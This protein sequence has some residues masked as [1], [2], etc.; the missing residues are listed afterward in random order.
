M[1]L[2]GQAATPGPSVDFNKHGRLQVSANKRFLQHADGTPFFYLGDTAW[3]MM[4]QLKREDVDVYMENRRASGFTVVQTV[5]L[6]EFDILDSPNAYKQMALLNKNPATPDVKPGPAND[7]WDHSDYIVNKAAEKGLYVG[8]L[9]T[10][11][12][13]VLKLW[14]H[15]PVVFNQ[16]NAYTYGKF[17]GERY[18]NNP[19]I[20]WILGGD[21][22]PGGNYD[23]EI[24]NKMAQGLKAGDGGSHLITYHPQG[25]MSSTSFTQTNNLFDFGSVQSGHCVGYEK[26]ISYIKDGYAKT[27]VKPIMNMEPHYE[28]HEKKSNCGVSQPA[29]PLWDGVDSRHSGY[30]DVFSGAFGHTYGHNSIWPICRSCAK[31]IMSWQDAMKREG[32]V[33]MQHLRRLLESRPFFSRIPDQGV[34]SGGSG[35]GMVVSTRSSGGSYSMVYSC[36]GKSFSVNT[37]KLTGSTLKGWWYNPRTGAVDSTF[38][39]A[40]SGGMVSYDPPGSVNRANDW[41]LVLDDASK[42]FAAPGVKLT[43][44]PTTPTPTPTPKLSIDSISPGSG[45]TTGGT[46][47]SITGIG[48]DPNR[49]TV[50]VDGIAATDIK[51]GGVPMEIPVPGTI[52]PGIIQARTPAHA[53]GTVSVTVTNPDGQKVTK[54]NAYT[55]TAVTIPTASGDINGDNKV[56]NLDF[57]LIV[58]YWNKPYPPADFNKNGKVDTAD[59]SVVLG[60]WTW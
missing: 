3:E 30:F 4:H 5:A 35:I 51:P 40:R 8:Y 48:I 24:W 57:S 58:T 60:K 13:K 37:A 25:T 32:S 12:D 34:A 20:I 29:T 10:W 53:P 38:T 54:A 31:S 26:E 23:K 2:P 46:Y 41:V 27:P 45:P 44:N 22:G 56:N 55:Y 15:G 39:A 1:L 7:Y 16:S 9:P 36:Y 19:N 59:L 14:G 52:T 21:R 11:G 47:I 50:S 28:D 42:G 18:K 17:L 33:T 49:A 43:G 6:A